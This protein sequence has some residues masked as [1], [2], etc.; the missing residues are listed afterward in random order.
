[1][2]TEFVEREVL[3]S[4]PEMFYPYSMMLLDRLVY[5]QL[6]TENIKIRWNILSMPECSRPSLL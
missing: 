5:Y 4:V 3:V 6:I 1:M 2:V